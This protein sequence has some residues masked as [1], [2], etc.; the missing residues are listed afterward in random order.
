MQFSVTFLR[1]RV[2]CVHIWEQGI[3]HIAFSWSPLLVLQLLFVTKVSDVY[4][5]CVLQ[6]HVWQSKRDR[7]GDL[8]VINQLSQTHWLFYLLVW[9]TCLTRNWLFLYQKCAHHVTGHKLYVHIC[10]IFSHSSLIPDD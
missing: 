7:C 10:S 3:R 8:S 5:L 4:P 2:V 1:K 6:A 9:F